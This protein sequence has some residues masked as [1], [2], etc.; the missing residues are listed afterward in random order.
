MSVM[1]GYSG[2]EGY[3]GLSGYSGGW[4]FS[5]YSGVEG[6]SGFGS[7]GYSGK[8]GYSGNF[9]PLGTSG[10]SGI[11]GISSY[12]G[13]EG[14]SGLSGYSGHF[15][16]SGYSG[17]EGAYSAS[18][19]SGARGIIG[20]SG[21]SGVIGHDGVSG[22]S[23][24]GLSG[25]SGLG[26]SGYSGLMGSSGSSGY[27]G[28]MGSFNGDASQIQLGH[29]SSGD[30]STGIG[31]F[32]DQTSVTDSIHIIDD[33]VAL[34]SPEKPGMLNGRDTVYTGT[35]K[36]TVKLSDGLTPSWYSDGSVAGQVITD[37]I[38]VNT[39]RLITPDISFRFYC[40]FYNNPTGIL[41]IY[42]DNLV[43][44][45]YDISHGTG[46]SSIITVNDISTYNNLWK[47]ANA[48]ADVEQLLDGY[49][50]YYFSHTLAGHTNIISFRY[51]SSN[52]AQS[53]AS[54]P[55]VSE[56]SLV[57]KYLSGVIYYGIGT[58]LNVSFIANNLYNKTYNRTQLATIA[59]NPVAAPVFSIP[60][61]SLAPIYTDQLVVTDQ[62]I[63]LSI[64]NIAS[65]SPYIRT[66]IF[67]SNGASIHSDI[68]L[69]RRV[70]TYG[71]VSTQTSELF[72]DEAYRLVL[73]SSALWNSHLALSN[74]NAQ[75]RNGILMYPDSGDYPGF[76]NT[77]SYE[78]WFYKTSASTGTIV[79]SGITYTDISPEG[80]GSLNVTLTLD[81]DGVTFDLGR[82]VGDGNGCRVSGSGGSTIFSFGTY[83]TANNNN[84][85]RIHITFRDRVHTIT[86]ITTS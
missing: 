8:S 55:T 30:W 32:S 6:G 50:S 24:L 23:G 5:G 44:D 64:A 35:T 63:T 19:Y 45:S 37:Y 78:R 56:N 40:G 57:S 47:K 13:N 66:T 60:S 85:Y 67:K 75:V 71:D 82:V 84:R 28:Q 72:Y 58:I 61:P 65:N 41:S 9:G 43:I 17:V 16:F 18:G 62:P 21:Y 4:G 3:S 70:C 29:P 53:F 59:V 86:N 83:S 26:L 49:R 51:D 25:Y 12:S 31:G 74:G 76:T 77:Q 42:R 73:G 14:Y 54:T 7:S 81:S 2:H 15:G 1:S 69:A 11:S 80:T 34:I 46:S 10:Y 33:I 48:Y 20:T 39:F 79:F 36:F 22:Y 38:L 27:S 52:P 68:T